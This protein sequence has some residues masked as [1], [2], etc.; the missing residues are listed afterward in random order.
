MAGGAKRDLSAP[1]ARALLATVR[2]RDT[3]GRTRRVLA[4]EQLGEVTAADRKL[5]A[6]EQRITAAVAETGTGLT[7]LFGMGRSGRPGSSATS[8]RAPVPD[9]SSLR[10]LHRHRPD[11]R[12]LRRPT[13]TGSTAPATAGSTTSCTSWPRSSRSGT[14]RDGQAYYRRKRDEGKTPL[15]ALRCLKRRLS[16]VVYRH[17]VHD[18]AAGGPGGQVGASP[19]PARLT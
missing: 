12:L 9:Q 11:R 17:L 7:G 18:L 16:D 5:K 10:Q 14:P 8:G 3:V 13:G 4:V 15:E 6:L 19:D 1:K 2:P